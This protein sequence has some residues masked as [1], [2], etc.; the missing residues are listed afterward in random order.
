MNTQIVKITDMDLQKAD[1]ENAAS[2]IKNGG[3]VVIPTETVYGLGGDG[4][5]PTSSKKY[6]PPRGARR[7]TP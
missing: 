2:I 6:T 4:T 1:I 7:I 5:K 3:L